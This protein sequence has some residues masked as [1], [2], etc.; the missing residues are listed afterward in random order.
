MPDNLSRR[1]LFRSTDFF[2]NEI[3]FYTKIIP[4]WEAFQ[5][6]RKPKNPFSEYPIC[7]AALCDGQNDYIALGD[8]N[9]EGYRAPNRYGNSSK[10]FTFLLICSKNKPFLLFQNKPFGHL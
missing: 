5:K 4:A 10:D 1:K 7:Y 2:Q 6:T 3:S 9:F 8:V